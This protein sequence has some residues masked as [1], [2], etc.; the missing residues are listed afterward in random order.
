MLPTE[1][2]TLF[3]S[4]LLGGIMRV[5]GASLYTKRLNHLMQL[6]ALNIRASMIKEARTYENPTF[7]WTRRA[8]ALMSVLAI[9]VLPKVVAI[10]LP[11]IP[12]AI[13]YP[14]MAKSSGFLFFPGSD[15]LR[16][17]WTQLQGIVITPLDTHLLSAIVGLYFG[18]SLIGTR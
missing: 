8:I 18:G 1:L 5:W 2:I 7:Q 9:V 16:V 14:E 3:G 15:T 17:K 6:Q 4:S 11:N 13:G 10:F 12:V